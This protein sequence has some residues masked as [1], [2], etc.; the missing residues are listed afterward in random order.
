MNWGT[1]FTGPGSRKCS[2]SF[3]SKRSSWYR[4]GGLGGGVAKLWAEKCYNL[5]SNL[6]YS[7]QIAIRTP[8]PRSPGAWAGCRQ[9]SRWLRSWGATRCGAF[10]PW[11]PWMSVLWAGASLR[12]GSRFGVLGSST[13]STHCALSRRHPSPPQSSGRARACTGCLAASR[14]GGRGSRRRSTQCIWGL[15]PCIR[16]CWRCLRR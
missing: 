3:R 7:P 4:R 11:G 8:C 5:P 13:S 1:E 12:R 15:R 10:G 6:D 14:R 16:Y 2:A 9:R